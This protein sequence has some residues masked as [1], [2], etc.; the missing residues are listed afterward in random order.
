MSIYIGPDYGDISPLRQ[1]TVTGLPPDVPALISVASKWAA[2]VSFEIIATDEGYTL[3]GS[4][5][6]TYFA[7]RRTPEGL[8]LDQQTIFDW[9][10]KA[11]AK[12]QI[13]GKTVPVAVATGGSDTAYVQH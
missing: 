9:N 1:L 2:D 12:H 10:L 7:V 5:G 6:S 13:S 4:D 11:H 3:R 8:P